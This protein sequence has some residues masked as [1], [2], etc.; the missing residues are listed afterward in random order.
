MNILDPEFHDALVRKHLELLVR[1]SVMTLNQ[2]RPY[3]SNWHISAVCHALER[4]FRGE[5]KR[6]IINLPPRH[7]KSIMAAADLRGDV[8]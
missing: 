6:L 2:G 3:L 1:R 7:L 8:Q 5:T 4:V